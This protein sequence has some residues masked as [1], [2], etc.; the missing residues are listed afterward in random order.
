MLELG[1]VEETSHRIVGRRV[2]DVAHILVTVGP[3]GE[4]IA[5]EALAV[6]MP[7]D[8]VF[9]IPTAEEAVAILKE[10]I[11]PSDVILVKASRSVGLDYIVSVLG[12]G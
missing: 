11:E 5:E 10:I 12:Q 9:I 4:L 8:K 3:L 7:E 6:G 1:P 2:R